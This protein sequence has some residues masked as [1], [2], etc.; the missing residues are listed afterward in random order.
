MPKRIEY[1]DG[2]KIGSL[3]FKMDALSKSRCRKAYFICKCGKMFKAN[4]G[5]VKQNKIKSC[6]CFDGSG[7]NNPN[8][9]HGLSNHKLQRIYQN[10]KTRCYNKKSP[11]YKNYGGRGISV[12]KEWRNDFSA[13]FDYVIALPG[14]GENG[15]TLDRI[16]NNGNYE[17][18]NLRWAN[19]SVQRINSRLRVDNKTGYKGVYFDNHLKKYRAKINVHIPGLFESA[20]LA[21]EARNQYI[22]DNKLT[23]YK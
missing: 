22:K 12:C 19:G 21:Y 15:L 14:Y 3:I 8:Y 10:I 16:D 13:F 18:G 9:K 6:G 23:E 20:K 5:D 4:I 17:P 7:D 1:K 11:A 2:D